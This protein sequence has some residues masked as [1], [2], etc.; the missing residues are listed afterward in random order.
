AIA[1]TTRSTKTS[2]LV[3]DRDTIVLG[4]LMSDEE[5]VS[6]SKVPLLGDIPILG[7]LFKG[8]HVDSTKQNLLMFLT[9]KIIHNLDNTSQ[10]LLNEKIQSRLNW[11]EQ[12]TGG[13]DPHGE[14]MDYIKL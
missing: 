14:I 7:W 4:G 8:K 13:K 10:Q 3:R 9:P 12:N 1:T 11:I 6:E 2:V 5:T